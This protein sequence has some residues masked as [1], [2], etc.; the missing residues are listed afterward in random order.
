[1]AGAFEQK[2][3]YRLDHLDGQVCIRFVNTLFSYK[4][5]DN[6]NCWVCVRFCEF[7]HILNSEI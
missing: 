2:L 4:M 7:Y 1:M 6:A 3:H 5:V